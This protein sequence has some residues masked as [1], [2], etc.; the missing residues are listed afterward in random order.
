MPLPLVWLGAA[1][2][3]AFAVKGLADDRKSQQKQRKDSYK[4]LTLRESLT[5]ESPVA[6]YPS[7]LF[8]SEQ[9]VKPTLGAVVCCGIGGVLEH[10]GI[11]IGDNTIIEL[12]GKGLIKPLSSERFTA[13]RS[14]KQIFIACDST[15]KPLADEHIAKQAINQIYQYR[16]YHMI[17]NNC[18]QFIWQ[19][20]QPNNDTTSTFKDLNEKLAHYFD[21]KVYWDVCD[22]GKIG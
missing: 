20:F 17:S 4:P 15:A 12:D 13:E 18:H 8:S 2:L 19:C 14:G 9:K 22:C 16:D 21:R 5:N 10:T 1:A 11:W 6:I 3:S 7:D